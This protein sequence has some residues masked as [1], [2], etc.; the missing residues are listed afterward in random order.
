MFV[1]LSKKMKFICIGKNYSD[2]V[3]EMGWKDDHEIALFMKPES[4][5]CKNNEVPYPHFSKDLQHELELIIQVNKPLKNVTAS[6]AIKSIEKISVGIDFTARDIQMELKKKG[7]PWEK[8]KSFDNSAVVGKWKKFNPDVHYEFHLEINGKEIQ[9]GNSKN[10]IV[11]F[12]QLLAEASKYFTIMPE[13][14]V[15]TGTPQ[16]V[17][18][19]HVGDVLVGYLEN[20]ALFE[21]KITS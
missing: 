17:G 12:A 6:E 3:K 16:N 13:D 7:M 1:S 21:I 2:H 8:S 19:V 20:E 14:I 5:W 9:R 10:M 15:F 11:N 18:S 4:A